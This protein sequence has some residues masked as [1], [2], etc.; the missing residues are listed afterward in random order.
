MVNDPYHP[1]PPFKYECPECEQRFEPAEMSNHDSD[2]ELV[3]CPECGGTL[4]NLTTP[5]HE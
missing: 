5:S 3:E 2:D 1:E 4:W